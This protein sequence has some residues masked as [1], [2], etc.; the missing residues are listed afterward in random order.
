MIE[1][2]FA[3]RAKINQNFNSM[4]IEIR[5]RKYWLAIIFGIVWMGG[6]LWSETF[7]ISL[8]FNL[9][10]PLLIKP[11]ILLWLII[12]TLGGMLIGHWILWQLIGREVINIKEGIFTLEQSIKGIGPKEMYE[13]NSIKNIDLNRVEDSDFW[14]NNT[15]ESMFGHSG[16]KIKFDYGTETITFAKEINEAEAKMILEE[17]RNNSNLR[18]R[19]FV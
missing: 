11:F 13:I 1:K 14:E 18:E 7:A 9:N 17:L 5:A 8:V 12:W 19:N 15:P 3:G 16:G 2:R 10:T 6:W 4:N